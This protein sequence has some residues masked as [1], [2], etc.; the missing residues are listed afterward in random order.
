LRK[1]FLV[2]LWIIPALFYSCSSSK[3]TVDNTQKS[4]VTEK[5]KHDVNVAKYKV[6]QGSLYEA[7]G[8]F[9]NAILEYQE[10]ILAD[11]NGAIYYL[12]AKNYAELSKYSLAMEN[13]KK[14]I[15]L[16]ADN[17]EYQEL[18]ATLFISTWQ[19]DS[20]IT[21]YE[22]LVNKDSSNVQALFNLA[23]LY[24]RSKPLS[25][26]QLYKKLIDELGPRWDV[27]IG[28]IEVYNKIDNPKEELKTL[29]ELMELDPGNTHLKRMLAEFYF[30]MGENEKSLE[31]YKD[32]LETEPD[33]N[34]VRARVASFLM[35]NDNIDNAI[36]NY[37]SLLLTKDSSLESTSALGFLYMRKQDFDGA[38][39]IFYDIIKSDTVKVETKLD[40]CSWVYFREESEDAI[41]LAKKLYEQITI[42][43]PKDSRAFMYLSALYARE[44]SIDMAEKIFTKFIENEKENP[45]TNKA[46]L[47]ATEVGRVC[48]SN[49]NF[50]KAVF[51]LEKTKDLYPNDLFLLFYLGFAYSQVG[52]RNASIPCLENA[53]SLNPPKEV[54]L[55][56]INQLGMNYEEMQNHSKSDSLYEIGLKLDPN[57]HLILN[58]Y[59]YS[60]SER[61]LQLEASEKMSRRALEFEPENS[62][63]LDTYGWILFKLGK[64]DDA[65]R[66]IKKALELRDAIGEDGSVL[67]EHLG[68][69]YFEIGNK[70]KALYH[71]EEAL[72]INPENED[73][74]N[75]VKK[76]IDK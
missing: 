41:S 62:A 13:I 21:I 16:N 50:E 57:N 67:N 30:R 66:Y 3:D 9:A 29:E 28:M 25:A 27:L 69:I 58:N 5:K 65:I 7:K 8:D 48:L 32:I 56:I 74:V 68:D 40:I 6:I 38:G 26:I 39:K 46:S 35:H 49:N 19:I 53:L 73:V 55:D 31:V 61:N 75:K 47:F 51:F 24:K 20:A 34:E 14:A 11:E 60:L 52:N 4:N 2:F 33:N 37:R 72:K 17:D 64:H 45:V 43:H 59:S 18:L 71:W 54:A 12:L 76:V 70:E 10:A 23:T 22:K 63:Y 36:S 1:Y 15:V 44:D 42:T